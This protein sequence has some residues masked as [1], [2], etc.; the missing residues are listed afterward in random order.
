MLLEVG[1]SSAGRVNPMAQHGYPNAITGVT[2]ETLRSFLGGSY[3]PLIDLIV[4]GKIKGVAAVVGCSNLRAKGHD[5][6]TVELTK[7]LIAK[8]INALAAGCTCGGLENC[9]LMSPEA[10]ELAGP[11]L[12]AVCQQL[13][14]PP[15]LPISAPAW[16]FGGRI[17]WPAKLRNCW[18]SICRSFRWCSLRLS[19]WKNRPWRTAASA[20]LWDSPSP[21]IWDCRPLSRAAPVILDVLTNQLPDLT[22]GKLIVDTDVSSSADAL[23]QV[24]LEKRKALGI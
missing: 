20:W 22:G 7:Q 23:E 2:E 18:A 4:Q 3:R 21:S 24:I 12:K 11:N 10:A 13:S 8:D 19:G 17:C 1:R 14:I 5:V 9:G 16:L 15:G 6:F